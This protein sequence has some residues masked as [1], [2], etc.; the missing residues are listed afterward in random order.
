MKRNTGLHVAITRCIG[1]YHSASRSSN[2]SRGLTELHQRKPGAFVQGFTVN[3]ML[4]T[5]L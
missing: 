4:Q 5:L 2:T 3:T 1:M